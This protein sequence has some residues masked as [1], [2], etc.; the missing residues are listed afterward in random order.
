MLSLVDAVFVLGVLVGAGLCW[1]GLSSYR[2]WTALGVT[3]F[4]GFVTILGVTA[5]IASLVALAG[6]TVGTDQP[7]P[8]WSQLGLL[9]WAISTVPWILFALQYT[10][11]YTDVT[12]RTTALF[13]LP[14]LGLVVGFF[15]AVTDT[16]TPTLGNVISSA[17]LIYCLGLVLVGIYL[18]LRS[19]Y[20]YGHFS[21]GLGAS[22]AIAPLI[23]F[24][25]LNS[26]GAAA[27]GSY[28]VA[29]I[30]F[31]G[32]FAVS[33]VALAVVVVIYDPFDTVPAVGTIGERAGLHESE[34]LIFVVDDRDRIVNTNETAISTLGVTREQALA[35]DIE[36]ILGADRTTLASMGTITLHTRAGP[37]Q[38][39][40]Q[41][42]ML[43][44]GP[45][46]P[47]G[48]LISLRDVTDREQR[49]QR[50][51]VLNRILRHNLR[52]KVDV[53]R[54]HAEALESTRADEHTK[55]VVDTADD[56]AALGRNARRIDRFVAD[57]GVDTPVD[58]PSLIADL[59]DD[60]TE[61]TESPPVSIDG[62]D[63]LAV[64]TNRRALTAAVRSALENAT[65]YAASSVQLTV[66]STDS[67]C[68]IQ[69][70]DDGPGIP[71]DELAS[72]AETTE[73]PLQ[74]GT[75]LGLWQLKWAVTTIGGELSF[76][77]E[78]G[79]TVTFTVPDRRP[80]QT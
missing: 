11:R 44:E 32:C 79:T 9:G 53:L 67:G 4:A 5:T 58:I 15:L 7:V 31:V 19:T 27:E 35:D 63:T 18:L 1:L 75:G 42:T 73:T 60:V 26:T 8:L 21:P 2:R 71:A 51:S 55:A 68:R 6:L 49:E 64:K 65:E 12:W 41:V 14:F 17:V 80:R 25:G 23:S 29:S 39:D 69:I 24:L 48:A 74:H 61:S 52:N 45:A 3:E 76:D 50:L 34:D 70:A 78:D 43:R 40:P 10:G 59:V 77:T 33:A 13:Y 57:E 36:D 66:E 20:A 54:S 72:L 37:R 38:Y 22:L 46:G 47:L 30:L 28:V 56:I 62:P 16:A